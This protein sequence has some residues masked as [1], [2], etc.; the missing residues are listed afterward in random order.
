MN[1]ATRISPLRILRCNMFSRRTKETLFVGGGGGGGRG[2]NVDAWG[3][4]KGD[5]GCS[6]VSSIPSAVALEG[7]ALLC[8]LSVAGLFSIFDQGRV[9]ATRCEIATSELR[10]VVRMLTGVMTLRFV[11]SMST[12][13]RYSRCLSSSGRVQ[14]TGPDP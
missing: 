9:V 14:D 4:C 1:P 12:S 8:D 13:R 10:L 5:Q 6:G 7:D 3:S 2:G 11:D